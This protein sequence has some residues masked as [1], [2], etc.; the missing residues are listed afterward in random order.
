M[1]CFIKTPR[2]LHKAAAIIREI[3]LP[4]FPIKFGYGLFSGSPRKK[5]T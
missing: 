3:C 2:N 5:A 1:R 4:V